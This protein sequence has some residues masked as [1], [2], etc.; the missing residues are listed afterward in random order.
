MAA[1]ML[2]GLNTTQCDRIDRTKEPA[3]RAQNPAVKPS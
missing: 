1:D 2:L 3:K